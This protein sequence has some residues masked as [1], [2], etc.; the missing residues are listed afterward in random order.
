[1]ESKVRNWE[2]ERAVFTSKVVLARQ[3]HLM[4]EREA[5]KGPVWDISS[6]KV[7]ACKRIMV[8]SRRTTTALAE[9]GRDRTAAVRVGQP[10]L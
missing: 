5:K 7:S 2:E 4:R 10:T 1:M 9:T 3:G 8:V 6:A